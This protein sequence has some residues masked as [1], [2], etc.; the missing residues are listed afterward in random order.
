MSG[1]VDAREPMAREGSGTSWQPDSTPM[2]GSMNMHRDGG[3]TMLSGF[4]APRFVSTGSARGDH[5]FDAPNWLMYMQ[6]IPLAGNSQL[7]LRGM[8]D[9][10]FLTENRAGYPLLF[11]TGETAYG[12][13]LHDRQHPH[14][15][16]MELAATY[17]K[18]IGNGTSASLYVGYPGE[19][20]LGPPAFMHREIAWDLP[21]APISHHWQDSTHI[22][23]GVVTAGISSGKGKIEAST[24]TGRDPDE[25]RTNFDPV[26][27][28]SYGARFSWNPNRNLSLEVS[29]G[30]IH[31]MDELNPQ[32]SEHRT[33]AS[34]IWN[35]P[36][37]GGNWNHAV[38]FGQNN[39]TMGGRT[40]S[41]LLESA[42]QANFGSVYGRVEYVQ[43]TAADLVLPIA[44]QDAR[45]SVGEFTLG[46]VH[47]LTGPHAPLVVGLGTQV[48]VNTK[49]AS[50]APFYGSATP[51]GYE[52]F[53]RL[54]P[55]RTTSVGGSMAGMG[56]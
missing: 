56:K 55:A 46:Y 27:L 33:S 5:R 47:N 43:K 50:L 6:S 31:S 14:D 35:N 11:Q 18:R 34:V 28:D 20:A 19:P 52:V 16:W 24:F 38:V 49:P 23:F 7:G 26:H 1:I 45:F 22:T 15:L 3:M 53:L 32:N 25:I 8:V 40:N 9:A 17:S 36:V 44:D 39:E 41:Y 30:Y 48:T 21:D 10:E 29:N 51:I 12:Q 4:A 42:Y 54:R 37:A 2:Y 13:P